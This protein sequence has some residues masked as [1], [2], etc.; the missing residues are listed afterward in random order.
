MSLVWERAP[1]TAGSLLVLLA[2]AD[3]ANDEGWCWPSIP[4]I[5]SKTRLERRSIQYIIRQLKKDSVIDIEE[6]RGRGH[7]HRYRVNVQNLRLLPSLMADETEAENAQPIAPLVE[8]KGA[9]H[10]TEKAQ[11]VTQKAQ[12]TTE[13][14]QPIAPDPLVEPLDKPSVDPLETR[15]EKFWRE[16][17]TNPAYRHID[18][19]VECG[20]MRAWLALPKNKSRKMTP[21]FVLN[22]LN[23][24]DPPLNGNGHAKAEVPPQPVEPRTADWYINSYKTGLK[25]APRYNFL[26]DIFAIP[27]KAVK[28]EVLQWWTRGRTQDEINGTDASCAQ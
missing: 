8:I 22:W 28:E 23:K 20:R 10:D 26:K 13:K 14:V 19:E 3:W 12:S 24:I 15:E 2:L 16:L 7:Q 21:P 1:Y 18:L 11:S 17:R 27:D 6:G 5:A 25:V 4:K 9:I